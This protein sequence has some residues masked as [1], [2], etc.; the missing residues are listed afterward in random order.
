MSGDW[1]FAG[2]VDGGKT[3]MNLHRQ[4]GKTK[5]YGGM[6]GGR[7]A[8]DGDA[9]YMKLRDYVKGFEGTEAREKAV[10]DY[11]E[12]HQRMTFKLDSPSADFYTHSQ[13]FRCTLGTR[14]KTL[15]FT[16]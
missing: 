2:S 4:R 8:D 6:S 13:V 3:W 15:V 7:Y 1:N 16:E 14:G 12:Q 10:C 11:L 9:G 5:L